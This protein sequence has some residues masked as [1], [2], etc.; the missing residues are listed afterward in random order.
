MENGEVTLSPNPRFV[1]KNYNYETGKKYFQGFQ[2][3]AL[4]EGL[5]PGLEEEISLC[6]VRSII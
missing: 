5:G 3:E 2:I 4:K 1:A 6:P